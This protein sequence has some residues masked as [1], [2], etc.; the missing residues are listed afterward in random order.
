[1]APWR[2]PVPYLQ[3][4]LARAVPGRTEKAHSAYG[5]RGAA[6]GV[7]PLPVAVR[8]GTL[9]LFP[10]VC[11]ETRCE[12][13]GP[14]PTTAPP[15]PPQPSPSPT[16]ESPSVY[17]YN[18]SGV[19][20]T[21]LL[22]SMGLQLNVTYRKEDNT[23]GPAPRALSRRVEGWSVSSRTPR[24]SLSEVRAVVGFSAHGRAHLSACRAAAP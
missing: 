21:C 22:A 12:Q 8:T 13:D 9:S 19:N 24:V 1:M 10:L 5:A 6:A 2:P 17:K 4:A 23:V 3:R 14:F 7:P 20:G 18:V 15:P 16:P 11:P